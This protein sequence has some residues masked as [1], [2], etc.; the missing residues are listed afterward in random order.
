VSVAFKTTPGAP[1]RAFTLL[2]VMVAVAIL[3]LGLVVLLTAQTGL[4]SSAKRAAVMSDA[5]GLARCKMSELEEHLLRN[6]FQ[7]MAEDDEGPCCD[8]EES[9]LRCKWTIAPVTLPE[10]NASGGADAGTG[11]SRGGLTLDSLGTAKDELSKGDTQSAVSN[12]T[13]MLG[14]SPPGAGP[15]MGAGALAPIAMG[16]I[17]PQLKAMLEAS[18]RKITVKVVW[19]EGKIERDLSV[20]QYITNPQQGGFLAEDESQEGMAGAGAGGAASTTSTKV[21]TAG[22]RG[23]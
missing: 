21:N 9:P 10:F 18:I 16:L 5:V 4:F 14:S 8:D 11:E 23:R 17:Y 2:E 12:I 3:G 19:M 7:L 1:R 20:T 6:G 15:S 22:R 13:E